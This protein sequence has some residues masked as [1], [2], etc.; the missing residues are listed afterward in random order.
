MATDEIFQRQWQWKRPKK[1]EESDDEYITDEEGFFSN[2]PQHD[3]KT[4]KKTNR[5]ARP[6]QEVL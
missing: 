4:I 3:D 6:K 1:E 2:H 5:L